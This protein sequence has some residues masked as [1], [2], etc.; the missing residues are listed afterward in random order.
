MNTGT[1]TIFLVLLIAW[2]FFEPIICSTIYKKKKDR[3]FKYPRR[4]SHDV[5]GHTMPAGRCRLD[6]NPS[7]YA[8]ASKRL[9]PCCASAY[10]VLMMRQA[11][12]Y[13]Q[14]CSG[15]FSSR[16]EIWF[17]S[18]PVLDFKKFYYIGR[19]CDKHDK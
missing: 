9:N 7:D 15:I 19:Q 11:N 3:R 10:P 13:T 17:P 18:Q 5:P 1:V 4:I 14:I 2:I 6:F 16:T 8:K 12:G